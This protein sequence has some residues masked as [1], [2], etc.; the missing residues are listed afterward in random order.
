MRRF[1]QR[2][3]STVHERAFDVV[4]A[5]TSPTRGLPVVFRGPLQPQQHLRHLLRATSTTTA[6]ASGK[7]GHREEGPRAPTSS[8]PR[9]ASSSGSLTV[10][11]PSGSRG[12]PTWLE[13]LRWRMRRYFIPDLGP[14]S[15]PCDPPAGRHTHGPARHT[16]EQPRGADRFLACL[17]MDM[18]GSTTRATSMTTN[19]LTTSSGQGRRCSSTPRRLFP[20][21]IVGAVA[22]GRTGSE[23]H[24]RARTSSMRTAFTL[25]GLPN[26]PAAAS[27]RRVLPLDEDTEASA[28]ARPRR[29]R[30]RAHQRIASTRT[31][32]PS[33]WSSSTVL[34]AISTWWT[35]AS[36]SLREI[37]STTS[38]DR[39]LG[40]ATACPASSSPPATNR[41][42]L[43]S[44]P[45][46]PT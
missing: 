46:E 34:V 18:V 42:P 31:S 21:P 9:W 8:P 27:H 29:D 22:V 28:C 15:P 38:P 4:D 11:T 3:R 24:G 37:R 32:S 13:A 33:P 25:V 12:R 16:D 2:P 10:S 40:S 43:S 45:P 39:G 26:A 35:S 23:R 1:R 19:S 17:M 30:R 36:S 20:D 41:S 6:R 5:R 14:A 44:R 7:F